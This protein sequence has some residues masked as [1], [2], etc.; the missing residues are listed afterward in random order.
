MHTFENC[1]LRS[2]CF[3][4][5]SYF[6]IPIQCLPITI[7]VGTNNESL[8]NNEFYIGLKQ[9]RAT[10]KVMQI[11]EYDR[12]RHD[13][14]IHKTNPSIALIVSSTNSSAFQ[15]YADLLQEFMTAVKQNYGEKVLVQVNLITLLRF[16]FCQTLVTLDFNFSFEVLML[17]H[18]LTVRRFCKPQCFWAIVEI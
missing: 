12:H 17:V 16:R 5:S 4:P 18:L 8:L 11:I 1:V 14:Q 13:C 7:D 10:G 9:R 3:W 15:E 2:F 6:W